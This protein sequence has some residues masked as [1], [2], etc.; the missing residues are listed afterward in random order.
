[1]YTGRDDK[2]VGSPDPTGEDSASNTQQ[3]ITLIYRI[4]LYACSKILLYA[5]VVSCC[6]YLVL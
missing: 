4:L 1:M 2:D 5:I 6:Q 3:L